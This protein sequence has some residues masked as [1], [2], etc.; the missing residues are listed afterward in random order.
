MTQIW[1]KAPQERERERDR[2]REKRGGGIK[3]KTT[4]YLQ[5][6]VQGASH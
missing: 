6:Q 2:E 1:N 5:P 4:D 3:P